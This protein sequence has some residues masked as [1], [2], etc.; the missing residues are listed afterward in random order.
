MRVLSLTLQLKMLKDS[1]GSPIATPLR[2]VIAVPLDKLLEVNV[3]VTAPEGTVERL[4]LVAQIVGSPP[5]TA[6]VAHL[7]K[8]EDARI[9][10]FYKFADD[11]LSELVD[12]TKLLVT[13]DVRDFDQ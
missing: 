9:K 13:R 1:T 4:T 8:L 12:D 3:V 10:E 7:S 11:L 6:L 5:D 2:R